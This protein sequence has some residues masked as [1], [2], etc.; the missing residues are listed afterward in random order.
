MITPNGIPL[1]LTGAEYDKVV[2]GGTHQIK[3]SASRVKHGGF[4]P[5]L[6][7]AL[8]TVAAAIGGCQA[9]HR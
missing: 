5:A 6:I 3:I 9:L 4:L 8:P 2:S 7:A 1:L